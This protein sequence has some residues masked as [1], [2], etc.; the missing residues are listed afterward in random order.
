ME[1]YIVTLSLSG[2]YTTNDVFN[3]RH[4]A[5]CAAVPQKSQNPVEMTGL[6]MW[7]RK[8]QCTTDSRWDNSDRYSKFKMLVYRECRAVTSL[9][10]YC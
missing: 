8:I 10:F 3:V 7:E 6:K 9:Q 5:R 1:L 2:R 4:A